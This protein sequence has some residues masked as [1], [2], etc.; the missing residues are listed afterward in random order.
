[1]DEPQTRFELDR[2]VTYDDDAI[3][4]EVRRVSALIPGPA[5]SR[6]AFDRLSKVSTD[7]CNRRFGS[8]QQTLAA[9]GLSDRYGGKAVSE[10]MKSQGAQWLSDEEILNELRRIAAALQKETLT[11]EDLGKSTVVG[12][13]VL[14]SRFGSWADA[15]RAAGL[16]PASRGRR[17]T[18]DDYFENL[19]TVWTHHG[20]PPTYAEMNEPPSLISNGGYAK[21]FGSWTLA[22]QRFVERVNADIGEEA[23]E[24][25]SVAQVSIR[26]SPLPLANPVANRRQVPLGLR[27]KVLRRDRFRC[28]TCG[29]TPATD[30][31]CVL[32]VDHVIPFS[33]GG[34]TVAENLRSLCQ[35]CN[36]GKGDRPA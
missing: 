25:S 17:W 3:I 1:M 26:S 35:A 10:K 28:V 7:T 29:R 15:L 32:H 11:Q 33:H 27:Y 6:R 21:K 9:A 23:A 12:L 18:D 8:W 31:S 24:E 30:L 22:K 34:K 20:R 19:L 4:A 36:L 16:E 5:M 14:R 13:R 2:L